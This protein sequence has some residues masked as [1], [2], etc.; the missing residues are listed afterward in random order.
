VALFQGE[1]FVSQDSHTLTSQVGKERMLEW[2]RGCV[3]SDVVDDVALIKQVDEFVLEQSCAEERA[4]TTLGVAPGAG[5][6]PR[7]ALRLHDELVERL[8]RGAPEDI[9]EEAESRL[10][11]SDLLESVRRDIQ[12]IGV[13]GEAPLAL[14]L[15]MIG[16]S[17]LLDEPL[18]AIVQGSTSTGKSFVAE[19][20]GQLFPDESILRAHDLSSTALYYFEFGRLQHRLVLAGERSRIQGDERAEATR[21]LREMRSDRC[22]RKCVTVKAPDGRG[23]ETQEIYQPGPI[24]YIESTTL[25]AVFDEDANRGLLLSTDESPAQTAQIVRARAGRA[26]SANEPK[27]RDRP[28]QRH[29]AMQRML[30]RVQVVVP[31]AERLGDHF[32]TAKA[33]A[34]RAFGHLLSMIQASAC[35]HQR[36]RPGGGAGLHHGDRIEA[37]LEDYA[38]ARELLL[39]PLAR[40]LGRKLRDRAAEFLTWLRGAFAGREFSVPEVLDADQ[41]LAK[42]TAHDLVRELEDAGLVQESHRV[43]RTVRFRL[44]DSGR[45]SKVGASVVVLPTVDDIRDGISARPLLCE[46]TGSPDMDHNLAS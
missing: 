29:H 21:A 15:F 24:A 27:D 32:P 20:V 14:S 7:E 8:L 11:S 45:V 9:R 22:L 39:E 33:E 2:A 13:V 17:R 3:G 38:V 46:V 19:R 28:I 35:L 10:V 26:A 34:R 4:E 41:N 18:S 12:T 37:T 31:F 43:G 5:S 25:G 42:S 40:A 6:D 44:A 1:K 36:Q 23:F 30:R 16:T